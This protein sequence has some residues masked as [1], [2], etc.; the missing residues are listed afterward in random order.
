MA[1]T[2][3]FSE[4][5]EEAILSR[6]LEAISDEVDKRQGSIAY[7]LSD[8]AAQMFAEAYINLDLVL[9][10]AFFNEDMPSDLLTIAAAD[11]GVDRKPAIAASDFI[12]L[13]GPV[14]QLVPAETQIRTD[15]GVYFLTTEDV[16]LTTG[17]AN[18][19]AEAAVG[20]TD[21]NV[22]VGEIDTVV[23]D[24]AGIVSVTN[25]VAFENGVDEESDVSLLERVYDKVRKP[26]TS[27]NVYHYEQ[28]AKEVPGVGAAKVYPVWNGP[29]SVKIVLLSDS[30]R[31][32]SQSVIDAT[33]THI[34]TERP[35]GADITVL[36]AEEVPINISVNLTL[37][38]GATVDSV[39]AD[40]EKG[41]AAYLETLA[42]NDTLVRYTRIAAVILDIPRVVDYTDLRVNGAT[43]NI[44]VAGDQV[45]VLGTV[46]ANA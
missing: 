4:Q 7:D 34:Q 32:P 5:T 31:R 35:V 8:P 17:T 22:E 30:K 16:T 9:T 18:V 13:N 43:G 12:V 28:W 14:G 37:A 41:T 11:F 46:I 45:A 27:G 29:N 20:G 19:L 36:G 23:G 42:F 39:K 6:L 33:V 21:G 40:I 15:T 2:P 38:A 10:Y 25:L 24:L 1:I 44:E 26:A 3:Q